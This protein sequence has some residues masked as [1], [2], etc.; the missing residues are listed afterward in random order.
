MNRREKRQ[1]NKAMK[2]EVSH[3]VHRA[4]LGVERRRRE[5]VALERRLARLS[6][7]RLAELDKRTREALAVETEED[8]H[9]S[10]LD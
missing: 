1:A 2:R 9:D 3:Q 4:Q 8:A 7:A 10:A 6:A 5:A